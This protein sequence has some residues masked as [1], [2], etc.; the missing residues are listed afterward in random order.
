M[1]FCLTCDV[2]FTC[3]PTFCYTNSG[4]V[5]ATNRSFW[6]QK[7]AH[8]E[9]LQVVCAPGLHVFVEDVLHDTLFFTSSNKLIE[10]L[11]PEKV[12]ISNLYNY[13]TVCF[14]FIINLTLLRYIVQCRPGQILHYYISQHT[15]QGPEVDPPDTTTPM[16]VDFLGENM[17]C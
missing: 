15:L 13:V 10:C 3:L 17:I 1:S 9:P 12:W 6:R 5:W 7:P 14:H 4:V 8:V 11:L 16:C 2:N